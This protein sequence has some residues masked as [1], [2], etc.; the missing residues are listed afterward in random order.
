MNYVILGDISNI[1][2]SNDR[3]II[4]HIIEKKGA[5]HNVKFTVPEG[6]K[7][8]KILFKAND[9]IFAN[10][11][12]YSFSTE[13]QPPLSGNAKIVALLPSGFSIYRDVVFPDYYEA[14]TDGERIYLKW[15]ITGK[16]D[17]MLSFKFHSTRNDYSLIVL[18]MVVM[19]F[20]AVFSYVVTYYKR[21]VKN[22]FMKGFT[23]DE[24]KVICHLSV[25]NVCMQKKIEKEFGFSRAKMTRIVKSLESKGLVEKE[26]V[27]RTNR[28]FYKK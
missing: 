5:E 8:L 2:I 18:V 1:T 23:E 28:I 15:D 11:N 12:I 6:T 24:K 25:K 10:E 3:G 22:E 17:V 7:N 13:L 20:G 9:L 19:F 16:E 4:D 21:K 26:K 27:G 14:L